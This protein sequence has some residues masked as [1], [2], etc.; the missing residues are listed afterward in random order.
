MVNLDIGQPIY[1][2]LSI[3]YVNKDYRRRGVASHLLE[4]LIDDAKHRQYR[5]IVAGIDTLN[6]A[7]I[8]LHET[9][10]FK[11]AGTIEN[12]GYKFERWLDLAFY[13]YDLNTD[14]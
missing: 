11:H 3:L 5:T 14:K 13:Q 1:I 7:S 4:H 10:N 9:F 6:E 12:V 2:L 8:K